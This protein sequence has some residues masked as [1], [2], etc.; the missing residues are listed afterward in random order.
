MSHID[1]SFSAGFTRMGGRCWQIHWD[2]SSVSIVTHISVI[3]HIHIRFSVSKEPSTEDLDAIVNLRLRSRVVV[4]I[5]S[6]VF[7]NIVINQSF[8][9]GGWQQQYLL[10]RPS[11][12]QSLVKRDQKM[13][14]RD[15]FFVHNINLFLTTTAPTTIFTLPAPPYCFFCNFWSIRFYM[16]KV[17]ILEYDLI[18]RIVSLCNVN[19]VSICNIIMD[20]TFIRCPWLSV[21]SLPCQQI[22]R[23]QLFNIIITVI[24]TTTIIIIIIIKR[25]SIVSR[26][27][28][29]I[30]IFFAS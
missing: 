16:V 14:V 15:N 3:G 28:V 30:S 6:S 5:P 19:V 1:G 13:E 9:D 8:P 25:S 2:S 22:P 26:H 4:F 12:F 27:L 23:L 29:Q 7:T 24:T 11:I 17:F 18:K 21:P 10:F 20:V